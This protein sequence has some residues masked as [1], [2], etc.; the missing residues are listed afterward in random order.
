MRPS[1]ALW[2]MDDLGAGDGHALII[3]C[4][5][6]FAAAFV[7]P[8]AVR[9]Q[10]INKYPPHSAL[11]HAPLQM[12]P[13]LCQGCGHISYRPK[14][15]IEAPRGVCAPPL[16]PILLSRKLQSRSEMWNKVQLEFNE[17]GGSKR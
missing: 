5:S 10:R 2:M 7:A 4:F 6:W 16:P 8:S 12:A 15:L 14:L 13:Y 1:P 9:R 17:R 3:G 11:R